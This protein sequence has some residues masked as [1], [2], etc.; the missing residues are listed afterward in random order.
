MKRGDL[1]TVADRSGD[2]A[3]KPRPAIIVQSDLFDAH[4]SVTVCLI[5][6][7][8]T[9]QHLFRVPVTPGAT[10][11][12]RFPSE[13]AVDKLQAVRADRVGSRIGVAADETMILVDQALRR[14]L[15]L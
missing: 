14:W 1:V 3:G 7:G 13:I 9:G 15:A 8:V 11:G 4:H 10:T 12:L 5:T 2:F 6:T